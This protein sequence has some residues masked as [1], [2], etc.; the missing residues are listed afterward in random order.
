MAV[1]IPFIM[2][3]GAAI[4]AMCALKQAEATKAASSYNAQ[5]R[6]RD[7]SVALDQ[8]GRDAER[9]RLEGRRAEGSLLAGYGASGVTLEGSPLDVLAMSASQA[10]LDEETVLYKGRLKA[11]GYSSAAE[12]ERFGGTTAEQQGTLNAASYLI[13]GAGKAGATYANVSRP[14]AYGE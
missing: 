14:F 10:K 8:A 7:A 6:E 2:L 11:S 12:L 1:A 13:G 4:S 5:L 3:A 9:V